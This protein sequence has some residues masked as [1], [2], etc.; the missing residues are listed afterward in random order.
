MAESHNRMVAEERDGSSYICV[1]AVVTWLERKG[2]QRLVGKAVQWII[3]Q[4]LLKRYRTFHVIG[5]GH[6]FLVKNAEYIEEWVDA[7]ATIFL[8][9]YFVVR[10]M[11][12]F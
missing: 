9:D 8:E 12:C 4:Y 5:H 7:Q 2:R 11:C 10:V 6:L 3:L 1:S